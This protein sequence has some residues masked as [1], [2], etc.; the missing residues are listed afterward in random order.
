M[1]NIKY[2]IRNKIICININTKL[3]NKITLILGHSFLELKTPNNR[4]LK[5][6]IENF[7][8]NYLKT[9]TYQFHKINLKNYQIISKNYEIEYEQTRTLY[10]P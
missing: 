10:K 3:I 9:C 6:K 1:Q 7:R 2:E 5:L 8:I 4:K